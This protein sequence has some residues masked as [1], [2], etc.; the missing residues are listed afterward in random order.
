MTGPAFARRARLPGV[1]A[2]PRDRQGARRMSSSRAISAS[3]RSCCG[4][5]R[6]A[7]AARL[8]IPRL[9]ARGRGR[10]AGAGRHR[11]AAER[12]RSC[13]GSPRDEA[14]CGQART[15]TSRSPA[16]SP[17]IWNAARPRP[18]LAVVPDGVRLDAP[19]HGAGGAS[20]STARPVVAYAGHLYAWKGVDVLVEALAGCRRPTG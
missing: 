15:A 19:G 14:R 16:A 10:A 1:R 9:C 2:R 6:H 20:A 17:T 3:R 11:N 7:A 13:G 5:R 18:R 12:R 8:R 4:C